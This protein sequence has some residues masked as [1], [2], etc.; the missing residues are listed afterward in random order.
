[1]E[2]SDP[3]P[4][5]WQ[6]STTLRFLRWQR[7]VAIR[8]LDWL[9]SPRSLR[10]VLMGLAVLAVLVAI[11]YAVT[12]WR[13]KRAWEQYKAQL[14]AQGEQLEWAAFIPPPVPDDQNFAM[15]PFLAPLFD[16]N[17]AA[18]SGIEQWRDTNGYL[19]V[20]NFAMSA[21][22][23]DPSKNGTWRHSKR[24]DLVAWYAEFKEA[25]ARRAGPQAPFAEVKTPEDQAQAAAMVLTLFREYDPV[26]EELR[27]ASQRPHARFGVR[28]DQA[29]PQSILLPHLDFLRHTWQMLQ[30]RASANLAL[31]HSD[32]AFADAKLMLYLAGTLEREPILISQLVRV[33]RFQITL[34][35]V[36]E[37]LA[38]HQWSEAQLQEFQAHFLKLNFLGDASR[39]LRAERAC[40]NNYIELLRTGP[41]R[42]LPLA[43]S[44]DAP[45]EAPDADILLWLAPRGWLFQEELNY[46]RMMQ[47]L[48]LPG[49]D[50][51]QKRIDPALIEQNEKRRE[52]AS[53]EVV[54][55]LFSAA[56]VNH[57]IL[58][59]IFL[60]PPDIVHFRFACAQATADQ[61]ALACALE[62][63]RLAEGRYPDQLQALVPRFLPQ[64][65]HDVINGQ[66]LKYRRTDDG[67][68]VLY[69]VGW[70]QT[71]EGGVPAFTKGKT[72]SPD[73][74]QGDWVWQYPAAK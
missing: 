19:R 46:S 13:G 60:P 61:A 65:P 28:Y 40:K 64:L 7:R 74:K 45:S 25:R 14:V 41:H 9:Y 5:A 38:Q 34:Q 42:N 70:N 52:E 23:P 72:Q 12:N 51:I 68:F 31:G 50:P 15:T 55:K 30:L 11:A 24:T 37:G 39:V 69:S 48:I 66:P 8:L 32:L 44:S 26:V 22:S 18:K 2:S 6:R 53:N 71:D 36:W 47:E 29:D 54:K 49:I 43:L 33:A 4:S 35:V 27:R 67:R 62:R 17:P 10:Q 63:C 57:S 20:K 59:A 73:L 56:M 21:Y 1:M 58:A 16:F 3:K